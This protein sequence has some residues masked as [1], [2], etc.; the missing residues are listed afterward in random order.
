MPNGRATEPQ[1]QAFEQPG[2]FAFLSNE[3]LEGLQISLVGANSFAG[4]IN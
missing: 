4:M 1:D 2:M 3:K